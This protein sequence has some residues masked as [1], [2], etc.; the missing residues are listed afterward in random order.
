MANTN[1]I[2]GKYKVTTADNGNTLVLG[3]ASDSVVGTY[4]L[5]FVNDNTFTGTLIVSGRARGKDAGM[6]AIA[7]VPL[8][9]LGGFVNAAVGTQA[10]ASTTLT[11]TSLVWVPATGITVGLVVTCTAGSGTL[12][13]QRLDGASA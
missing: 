10:Y 8:S 7:F 2:G 4:L 5:H 3:D 9:Y 12:Y 6:D 1:V 11:T 13:V